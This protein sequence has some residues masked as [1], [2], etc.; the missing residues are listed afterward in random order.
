MFNNKGFSNILLISIILILLVAG[1]YFGYNYLYY[2]SNTALISSQENT[3]VTQQIKNEDS[4]NPQEME[5]K[6]IDN[7]PKNECKNLEV[8]SGSDS[9]QFEDKE[10]GKLYK[11]K[12]IPNLSSKLL[13]FNKNFIYFTTSILNQ[14]S[15]QITEEKIF[16]LNIYN[17]EITELLSLNTNI[18]SYLV[19]NNIIYYSLGKTCGEV[20]PDPKNT[21]G[22]KLYSY[23]IDTKET[24]LL[25]SKNLT[26]SGYITGTNIDKFSY[27]SGRIDIYKLE[28][29]KLIISFG[30]M[31]QPAESF[32]YFDLDSK[33]VINIE[34]N[35]VYSGKE[36]DQ[37]S[38]EL[39]TLTGWESKLF[40]RNGKF[41]IELMDLK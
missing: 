20:C 37:K 24:S 14:D 4:K 22:H 29:N 17:G 41:E 18:N 38:K 36:L 1:G 11:S 30:Q 16:S 9:I 25:N 19:T 13:K 3:S 31:I 27:E 39:D 34:G 26:D 12:L 23:N 33:E 32:F 10:F 28:N 15:M 7:C 5:F 2:P 8:I 6:G 40:I 21:Y 35:K